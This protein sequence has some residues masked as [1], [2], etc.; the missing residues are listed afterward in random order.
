MKT[1][2]LQFYFSLIVIGLL[3]FSCQKD[4]SEPPK[5]KN[6]KLI[7]YTLELPQIFQLTNLP[8]NLPADNPLTVQGIALGKQL[9]YEKKLSVNNSIS[10]SSCHQPQFAFNDKDMALSK[11][12]LGQDGVR[13]AMPIFNLVYSNKFNWH[14]SA[15]SLEQQ[16]L[17]PVKDPAE[18]MESWV[19]VATKLKAIPSYVNQFNLVFPGEDIDSTTITK[20]IAQFERTLISGNSRADNYFLIFAGGQTNGPFLTPQEIRGFEVFNDQSKGD[21][22]HCHGG[23]SNPLWTDFQF[24]NNGLDLVPDSGLALVTKNPADVGKWKTPSLRNLLFTAPYM[25]DGRFATIEEV[26]EFYSTGVQENS[27]NIDQF[28]FHNNNSANPNLS[29]QDKADLVAFLKAL[30]DSS[31]VNNPAFRP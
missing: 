8:I 22:T 12:A 9:F 20:A 18:M 21:C 25:H 28:M 26:V 17:N 29:T 31:F 15:N 2:N 4:D 3:V 23:E 5:D 10:C 24:R 11:G 6:E 30:S 7:P 14:G 1:F 19:N 16:A 27:P 13:N